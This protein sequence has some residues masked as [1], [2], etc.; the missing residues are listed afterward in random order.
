[1]KPASKELQGRNL[2]SRETGIF[3]LSLCVTRT[4]KAGEDVKSRM[5]CSLLG[6]VMVGPSLADHDLGNLSGLFVIA[7]DHRLVRGIGDQ[8]G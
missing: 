8:D 1:M 7:P 5:I 2:A 3:G 6:L 4:V